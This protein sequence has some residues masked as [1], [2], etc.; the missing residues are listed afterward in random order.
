MESPAPGDSICAGL[1]APDAQGPGKIIASSQTNQNFG[2][3]RIS[4]KRPG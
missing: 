4:G 1:Q 2:Y 3:G